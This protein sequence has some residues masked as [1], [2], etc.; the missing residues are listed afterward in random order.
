MLTSMNKMWIQL[1]EALQIQLLVCYE[2]KKTF[3]QKSNFI[4]Q[5]CQIHACNVSNI[6]H[7]MYVIS[8]F[9]SLIILT[10]Y[11]CV[12]QGSKIFYLFICYMYCK[13]GLNPIQLS[14]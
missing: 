3:K 5:Y 10:N 2:D 12:Y 9:N 6:I 11:L 8:Q 7:A 13:N 4:V 14:H 1:N